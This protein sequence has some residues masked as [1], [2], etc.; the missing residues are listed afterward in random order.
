MKTYTTQELVKLRENKGY[1]RLEHHNHWP[2][3]YNQLSAICY[4][5][6]DKYILN[7]VSYWMQ[8]IMNYLYSNEEDYEKRI[9]GWVNFYNYNWID[10]DIESPN[11]EGDINEIH[12]APGL[13]NWCLRNHCQEDDDFV[14]LWET[15]IDGN[16]FINLRTIDEELKMKIGARDYEWVWKLKE[17]IPEIIII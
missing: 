14:F 4:K 9:Q 8:E 11:Y 6:E 16:V 2:T 10:E 13:F 3:L 17:S 1:W 7:D 12:E 5:S 15:R